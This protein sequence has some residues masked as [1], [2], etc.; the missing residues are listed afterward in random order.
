VTTKKAAPIK[1]TVKRKDG[2]EC[3]KCQHFITN[4]MAAAAKAKMRRSGWK[5]CPKGC[6]REFGARAMKYHTP[7]CDGEGGVKEPAHGPHK[8]VLKPCPKGCGHKFG[9]LGMEKH[10]AVCEFK[11][12]PLK[13]KVK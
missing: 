7:R 13:R 9:P 6:G 2:F 4:E 3:P 10:I 1:K 11:R 12:P 8:S 5:P